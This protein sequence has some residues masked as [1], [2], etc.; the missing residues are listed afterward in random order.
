MSN[1]DPRR[2]TV[3]QPEEEGD[4]PVDRR[5]RTDVPSRPAAPRP[6]GELPGV[7]RSSGFP[8]RTDGPDAGRG[9]D[10]RGVPDRADAV[11][12]RDG[13]G[14]GAARPVPPVDDPT[15]P[16]AWAEVTDAWA[17][18]TD[19]GWDERQGPAALSIAEP[20]AADRPVLAPETAAPRR[21][22]RGVRP[23]ATARPPATGRA[24][25]QTRE[26]AG[27]GLTLPSVR[28][29]AGFAG[30]GLLGD[31]TALT[32]LGAAVLSAAVM[33]LVLSSQIPNLAPS[34]TLHLDAAGIAD[35]FGPPQVLWRLPLL[36]TMAT[37]INLV[38][39]W[40]LARSDRFAARFLL[41]ATLVVHLIAWVAL[42]DFV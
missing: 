6:S 29:P 19:D 26:G 24:R 39:A 1:R 4:P 37:L 28:L 32:L 3:S 11:G 41:A 22:A 16:A 34:L 18:D 33:A 27:R 8:W 42:F 21:V 9:V 36:A 14:R 5:G 20:V 7:R 17:A 31:R 38:L 13:A 2:P 35:R 40:F 30:T 12:A 15:D 25:A 23:P 10:D